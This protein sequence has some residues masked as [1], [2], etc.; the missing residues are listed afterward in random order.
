MTLPSK[1]FVAA[2]SLF[3][4][5]LGAALWLEAQ[6]S[7]PDIATRIYLAKTDGSEMKV[8]IDMPEYQTLGSPTWSH[9]GKLIAFDATRTQLG[10]T[11]VDSKVIV[12]DADGG[13]LRI[14]G[15]GAMP[16]FSPRRNRIAFS[17]YTPNQ[18]VWVMSTEGPDKELVLLDEEGWSAEWSPDG[19][20][21]VYMVYEMNAANLITFDLV[22]GVR[23]AL[24]E[25][26]ASPYSSFFWNFAWSP[27][28]RYIAFKGQRGEGKFE[29]GIVDAR[30]AKQGLVTRYE[31]E[32]T[33]NFAWSHDS[34][35]IVFSQRTPQ[36]GGRV[37]LY[38]L[39]VNTME[40]PQLLSGQDPERANISGVPSPDGK[41]MLVASR[42]PP[43]KAAGKKA[44]KKKQN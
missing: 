39:D 25:P 14:L 30:G 26:G 17:R 4:M 27:D 35:H 7:M 32:T 8:L 36:R 28:G 1:T 34:Q 21:I 38:S 16:S 29:V 43:A 40:R 15:D 20:C 12:A 42:K 44:A 41:T 31:G 6:E 18:G 9:D 13:N 5:G 22:E 37:Q 33:P 3:A 23:N 11:N 2:V 24:F 10:E 19:K